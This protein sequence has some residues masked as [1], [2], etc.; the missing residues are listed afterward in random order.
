MS[1][2][3]T[4]AICMEFTTPCHNRGVLLCMKG[5]HAWPIHWVD[6]PCPKKVKLKCGACRTGCSLCKGGYVVKQCPHT[7]TVKLD[8]WNP[9]GV[10]RFTE[11]NYPDL[12][13][14]RVGEPFWWIPTAMQE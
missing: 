6:V 10:Q 11:K 12:A 13:R 1:A 7:Y 9:T 4:T 14:A 5:S 2:S 8:N 3:S